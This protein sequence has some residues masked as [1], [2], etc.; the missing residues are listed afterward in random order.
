MCRRGYGP[1]YPPVC[2][3]ESEQHMSRRRLGAAVLG[4][5]LVASGIGALTAAGPALAAATGGVGATLPYVEVQAEN[6][7]NSGSVIGPSADYGTLAHEASYRKAGTLNAGQYV[8]FT[9]P[10]PTNSIDFRYS[11]PD[12]SG[13]SV[14]T[15]PINFSINGSASTAFTLTNAYSWYYS[16]YPF[17]KQPGSN[18][19]HFY[20]ET[21]R[22][23]PT[24][25]AAGTKF[26]LTA[27]ST[28]TIDFADF[29][30]VAGALSQP[31]GSVS[32]TSKGAAP[33]G[34][35]DSTAA[36]NSAIQSAGAG[37]TV[38][39]PE[40]TFKI[41]GSGSGCGMGCSHLVLNNV[42]IKG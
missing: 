32:V 22:L 25:Y 42:T 35:A 7:A 8:E 33:P 21:H 3:V 11:I 9:T 16:S 13:G 5:A 20:D 39:I 40:G 34:A 24:S 28:T 2:S 17:S 14:Y 1:P 18:P 29:E 41:P 6:S 31:S 12:T 19:H 10:V 36:F 15:T 27:T 37:G 23:L 4:T 26:R 30:S 38:F